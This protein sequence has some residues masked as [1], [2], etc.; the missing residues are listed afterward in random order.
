M[1]AIHIVGCGGVGGVV[2]QAFHKSR[3]LIS[4]S[5]S[6]L[7]WDKDK[8]EEKN[9]DRQFFTKRDIGRHKSKSFGLSYDFEYITEW[10]TENSDV[11]DNDIIIV[12]ADN[13]GARLSALNIA[14]TKNN[15]G[16]IIGANE[17]IDAESY[18]YF[19]KWKDTNFDP[20]KYYPILLEHDVHDPTKPQCTGHVLQYTPQLAIA[21]MLAGSYIMF[22]YHLWYIK[23]PTLEHSDEVINNATKK[24]NNSWGKIWG[25]QLKEI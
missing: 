9:L 18:I 12:C 7:L 16:V 5:Y 3:N 15:V 17:T 10:F 8:V 6:L 14:D 19:S 23:M 2:I 11:N 13:N 24:V 25:T 22:L 4:D 21:N 1:S 20:R